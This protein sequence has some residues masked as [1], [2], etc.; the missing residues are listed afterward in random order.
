MDLNHLPHWKALK[1]E[2]EWSNTKEIIEKGRDGII[3]ELT[4]VW[5][6]R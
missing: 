4:Q 6:K 3:A 1:K 2:D 5:I